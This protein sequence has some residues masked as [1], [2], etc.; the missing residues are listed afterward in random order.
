M[1]KR[2]LLLTSLFI[3]SL[4][5]MA[6]SDDA[7]GTGNGEDND[8]EFTIALVPKLVGIPYFNAT[9]TGAEKAGEDL[10][11]NVIY[12]GPTEPDAAQQ[13]KVIEDLISRGVDAIAVAPNDPAALTPVLK[14]ARDEGILVLDWDTPAEKEVVDIG[15][16]QIDDEEYAKHIFDSLVEAM[17]TDTGDFAIITGGLSAAN[18]NNWIDTG[19]DYAKSE[20]PG[21]NLVTERVPSDEKQQ[22]AYQKGLEL[23]S[24][25]PDLKGIIGY[26]TPAPLG[27]AQAVQERGLQ[28]EIAVVGTALPTDS[29]PYLE[30]GSLDK[31][32][33][34]DPEALGY[35]TIV[36]ANMVLNGE[37]PED[38]QEI[39]NIGPITV[40]DGGDKVI[41]GP[42]T[43]FTKDN[44]ADFDF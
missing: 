14:R 4:A 29:L 38:G 25:Y 19:L 18:I 17:G 42:P 21:L 24:A 36:I 34:W 8:G 32:I 44:A 43:D 20:Y 33:L 41:L 5:L 15:V 27:A 16:H 1:K 13:V 10:G 31:A 39:D 22:V 35:L 3:L 9:E 30:D 7:G 40:T 23:I 11:I 26:S 2:L 12:T 28:D 37:T 6:C